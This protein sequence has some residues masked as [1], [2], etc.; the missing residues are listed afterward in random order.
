MLTGQQFEVRGEIWRFDLWGNHVYPPDPGTY[1]QCWCHSGARFKFCHK[2]RHKET[3]Q[4][5]EEM[6]RDWEQAND[7]SVCLHPDAPN[8]CSSKIID[9]HVVQRSGGGLKSIARAGKVYSFKPHPMFL[10]KRNGRLVPELIGISQ[11]STFRG[12]CEAHDSTLFKPI[13]TRNFSSDPEQ[14]LLLNFRAVT[15][16]VHSDEVGLRQAPN[17]LKADRGRSR[18]EQRQMFVMAERYREEKEAMLQNARRLKGM[19]DRA[20]L[21]RRSDVNGL[22]VWFDG[23]PEFMCS[24]IVY[25]DYDF[26]GQPVDA[27]HPPAHLCFYTLAIPTGGWAAVWAWLGS[28]SAA[29]SLAASFLRLPRP[30]MPSALMRYALEYIDNIFLAPQWWE[31]RTEREREQIIERMS[32]HVQ[33]FSAR[34]AG[35]ILDDGLRVTAVSQIRADIVGEW[36]K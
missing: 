27:V 23:E 30:L 6:L 32:A 29:E 12:F 8:G 14:L 7:Y 36:V 17:F 9:A 35:S 4:T 10:M 1:D 26:D 24:S 15:R 11:A 25:V 16:R 31:A 19:Y 34:L 22:A 5:T 18:H 3:P 2:F 13:E 20:V 21:E 33:P 28:N